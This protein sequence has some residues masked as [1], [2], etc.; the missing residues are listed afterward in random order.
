MGDVRL[1]PVLI[2]SVFARGTLAPEGRFPT[3]AI[4]G[5]GGGFFFIFSN[6]F[7]I[8]KESFQN[9]RY[10]SCE[11]RQLLQFQE[12]MRNMQDTLI[13]VISCVIMRMY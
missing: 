5:S 1:K 8:R 10:L 12:K 11:Q 3:K 7:L 9:G 4:K 13:F 2:Y 6:S